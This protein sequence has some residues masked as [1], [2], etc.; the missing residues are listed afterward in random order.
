M[1]LAMNRAAAAPRLFGRTDLLATAI[2]LRG[3]F[4]GTTGGGILEPAFA[5]L[6][7]EG[8][9]GLERVLDAFRR[10]GLAEAADSWVGH[11]E[12]QPISAEDVQRVLGPACL[13]DWAAASGLP[14]AETGAQLA[15]LIP[16]LADYLTP[17]ARI[18]GDA[19]IACGLSV[20]ERALSD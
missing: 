17:D 11:G 6:R 13:R 15:A 1:E 7:A 14:V 3:R 2:A 10:G 4:P 20:L 5:F 16:P 8:G 12:N 18:P 19:L 9:A